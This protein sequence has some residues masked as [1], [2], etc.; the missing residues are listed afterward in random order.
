[1]KATIEA[2]KER[3]VT[4][5]M[6]ESEALILKDLCINIGHNELIA[7]HFPD[8]AVSKG[9]TTIDKLYVVLGKIL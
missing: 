8:D 9:S 4:L 1:M 5:E 6:T 7:L 2:P 3:M